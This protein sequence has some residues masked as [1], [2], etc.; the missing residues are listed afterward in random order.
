MFGGCFF[1]NLKSFNDQYPLLTPTI[2]NSAGEYYENMGS[3]TS[4]S[5]TNDK[6]CSV[7]C[8]NGG[9]CDSTINCGNSDVCMIKCDV[10]GAEL[11]K[12]MNI[13]AS[14]SSTFKFDCLVSGSFAC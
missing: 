11:C 13:I 9:C 14:D 5:C 2:I 4:V 8:L 6:L 3:F 7:D 12:G 1:P 10:N